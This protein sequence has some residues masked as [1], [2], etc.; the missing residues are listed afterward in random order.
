MF[1]HKYFTCNISVIN[2]DIQINSETR[3]IPDQSLGESWL[4]DKLAIIFT[5]SLSKD[6]KIV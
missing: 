6:L 1:V 2:D 4:E 5:I 3:Y